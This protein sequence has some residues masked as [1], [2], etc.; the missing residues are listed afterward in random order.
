MQLEEI[1]NSP[2]TAY[3]RKYKK[4]FAL[5]LFF[6]LL[7]N[8]LDAAHPLV[9]KQAID[10]IAEG[11]PATETMKW[12][13]VFLLVLGGLSAT[14][15]LWRVYFGSYHTHAAEDIRQRLFEHVLKLDPT[16]Y[17]KQPSGEQ[18][19]LLIND[20][21]AYRMAIGQAVLITIDGVLISLFILPMMWWLAPSW[22]LK[23]LIFIPF[24]P[25]AMRFIM[26][27]VNQYF[28]AQQERLAELSNF[29]QETLSG[30]KVIKSFA[31][32]RSRLGQFR[33]FNNHLL[34][35]SQKLALVDSAFAPTMELAVALGSAILI[36]IAAPDLISGTVTVGTFIAYQRY[37]DKMI[38]PMTALGIGLSQYQKGMA[39]FARIR[40]V[41]TRQSQITDGAREL[42]DVQTLGVKDLSFCYPGAELPTLEDLNFQIQK[43]QKVGMLG[44][45]GSGKSTLCQL[46]VRLYDT[47]RG[48]VLVNDIPHSEFTTASLRS[49]VLLVTQEPTLFSMSIRDNLKLARPSANDEDIWQALKIADMETEVLELPEKLD[50]LVGEKGVNFSGGQKQ[51]LCLARALISHP[52]VL[53]LDDPLSAVDIHTEEK[54]VNNLATLNCTLLVISHRLNV[55]KNCGR[56]IVLNERTIEAE[57]DVNTLMQISP[58]FQQVAKLQEST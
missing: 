29:V 11:A 44:P 41:L 2:L 51:R 53:I 49:K 46:L 31:Q 4:P 19:S 48:E 38:W 12:G 15:Y 52:Q 56:I 54:I 23:T 55:L 33:L 43:G 28:K 14:R 37:I 26:T 1:L 3:M 22:M 30:I 32:E 20:V 24:L 57:G 16:Y 45:V 58:T 35:Q 34:E 17:Q 9:I 39:S 47:T 18:V 25:F 6:L 40:E 27:R 8:L 42:L 21:Q 13:G 36:F 7:T 5:G 10:A 50:S